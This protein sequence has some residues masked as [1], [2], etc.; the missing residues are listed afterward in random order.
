MTVQ[1]DMSQKYSKATIIIHWFSTL[2]IFGLFFLG[3]SLE[4][5]QPSEKLDLLKPHASLG[6]LL[7]LLTIV[8]SILFFKSPR[9]DNLQ[10]GSK[11]NDKLVHYIHN[12][13]YILL[14]LIGISGVVT[15]IVGGYGDALGAND[16]QLIKDSETLPS[17][18][19]HGTL[20]FLM[21]A[22]VVLHVIGV[23]K[24]Y[25]LTKENTLKRIV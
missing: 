3:L 9:P 17:L 13:F 5:L 10:T 23:A 18:K 8:R 2:L 11:I 16:W 12:G 25:L 1:N 20:S 14:L 4:S 19:A 24:H 15:M 6:F 21:M 7:F 22:L